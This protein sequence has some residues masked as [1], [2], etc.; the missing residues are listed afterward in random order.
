MIWTASFLATFGKVSFH[1]NYDRDKRQRKSF[2]SLPGLQGHRILAALAYQAGRKVPKVRKPE[3]FNFKQHGEKMKVHWVVKGNEVGNAFGYSYHNRKALEGVSKHL[4]IDDSGEVA[5]HIVPADHFRPIPG[6]YNVLFTMWEADRLPDSYVKGLKEADEIVVPCRFSK[7]LFKRYVPEKKYSVCQHGVDTSLYH[8]HERTFSPSFGQKF[9]ILWVGAPN[10]RKGYHSA[11]QMVSGLEH[12]PQL[13]F[14][15]KTTVPDVDYSK[16]EGEAKKH[17]EGKEKII[18]PWRERLTKIALGKVKK[19]H[20]LYEVMGKNKNVIFDSRTIPIQDLIGLYE[21][22]HCFLFPSVG[23]GWGL[24]LTEAMATGLPCISP[25]HTGMMD[26]FDN[27]V[28]YEV[29]YS[30]S[31]PLEMKNYDLKAS[32]FIPNSNDILRAILNIYGNY[33]EAK[34]RGKRASERILGKFTWERSG[35]RLADILIEA[36]ATMKKRG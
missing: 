2:D 27:T 3:Y 11:L 25:C 30:K 32:V 12:N 23:E 7:E 31:E 22:A 16:L 28:G 36:S 6:K 17:L 9:R 10:P 5:L 19:L 15:F 13:E 33:A 24:T 26:Y 1:K 14:Y 34:K 29:G 8:Y 4:E 18:K 20:G 35:R 21:S